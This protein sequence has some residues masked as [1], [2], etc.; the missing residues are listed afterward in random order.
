MK[1]IAALLA[2]GVA[3]NM[4]ELIPAENE[5]P[6]CTVTISQ[7]GGQQNLYVAADQ[8]YASPS[9]VSLSSTENFNIGGN[10]ISAEGANL[11]HVKFECFLLGAS[12][13]TNVTECTSSPSND[14]GTCV[15]PTGAPGEAWSGVFAFD[16]PGVA[17]NFT[18]EVHVTGYNADESENIFELMSQFKINC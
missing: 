15:K 8:T 9:H 14:G 1:T 11:D 5:D 4:P 3:A 2:A 12:V 7:I 13:Y 16:V 6:L 17:P 10:W 18:Y